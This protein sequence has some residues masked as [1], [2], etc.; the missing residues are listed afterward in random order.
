MRTNL[1][2]DDL[3]DFLEE[4]RVAVLA[5]LRRDGSPLLSPVWHRWREGGFELWIGA[6]DVK[7]THLRRDP[8]AT[9][10]VAESE[11]P[12]RGVEVRG[13]AELVTRDVI[14][15]AVAIASRYAGSA[16]GR[17]YVTGFSGEQLIVRIAPGDLRA[18]DFADDFPRDAG[19]PDA[20]R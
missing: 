5:T 18:W 4:P 14:E 19:P 8:R 20:E 16:R 9:L 15:T 7:V 3:G 11:P 17:A 2:I 13:E 12:Y 6:S 10:V 1:S